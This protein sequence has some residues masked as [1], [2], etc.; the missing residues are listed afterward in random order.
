[1]TVDDTNCA[2]NNNDKKDDDTL[3]R[4]H[5]LHLQQDQQHQRQ[6]YD[7][8]VLYITN[9]ASRMKKQHKDFN[10]VNARVE[11]RLD[12]KS[13]VRARDPFKHENTSS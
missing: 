6:Q 2:D 5:N 4:Y 12:L 1:M 8:L 9:N 10:L 13:N 3:R 7:M 11:L